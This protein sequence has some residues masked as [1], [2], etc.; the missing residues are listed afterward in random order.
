MVNKTRRRLRH[1]FR[2]RK[3]GGL[4]PLSPG[5]KTYK[6]KTKSKSKNKKYKKNNLTLHK[7]VIMK[8]TIKL[9]KEQRIKPDG[10][11]AP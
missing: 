3:G 5:P 7:K 10:S 9:Y 8:N 11:I 2:H 1:I 6:I 4:S